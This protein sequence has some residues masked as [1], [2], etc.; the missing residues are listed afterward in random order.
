[1][2]ID[3]FWP[4]L[5]VSAMVAGFFWLSSPAMHPLLA[6]GLVALSCAGYFAL[7]GVY[8]AGVS[9]PK[10]EY[11]LLACAFGG[12]FLAGL[13]LFSLQSAPALLIFPLIFSISALLS[14]ARNF[15]AKLSG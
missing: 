15:A 12:F 9:Y 11:A 1:M 5:A 6:F 10:A 14:L 7:H 2:K 13:S 4:V 8:K 3:E